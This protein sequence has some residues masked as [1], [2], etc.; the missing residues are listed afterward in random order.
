MQSH[1]TVRSIGHH[2]WLLAG[3]GA[4]L[5]SAGAGSCVTPP[6]PLTAEEIVQ[7][8]V[9]RAQWVAESNPRAGYGYTKIA[10]I[11]DFDSKGQVKERKEKSF[12]FKAGR[13]SMAA[14]KINGHVLCGAELQKQEEAAIRQRQAYSQGKSARRDDEWDKWL[15]ADLV[16]RYQFSVIDRQVVNGRPAYV[17]TFQPSANLEVKH[18][19]DR[20][21]NQLSGKVWVDEQEFEI[22]RAEV[23]LQSKVTLGGRLMEVLGALKR[24]DFTLERIR[25]DDGVWFVQSTAGDYEGRKLLD[26]S[27]VRITT[28]A[29]NFHKLASARPE[30]AGLARR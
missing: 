22:A 12:V 9:A 19:A 25:V 24:L 29:S 21:L 5:L 3:F 1:S 17:L 11:E 13:G 28:G 30:P 2:C 10:V 18:V 15:T 14:L 4:L 8:T 20:F 6:A 16:A 26:T 23:A 27:R 7:K